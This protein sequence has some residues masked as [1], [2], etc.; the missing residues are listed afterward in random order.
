[1]IVRNRTDSSRGGN[2]GGRGGNR[3]GSMGRG[4]RGRR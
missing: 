1:M 4:G 2:R 3:G